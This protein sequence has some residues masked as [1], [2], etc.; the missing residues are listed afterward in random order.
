MT[1]KRFLK[2]LYKMREIY[3]PKGVRFIVPALRFKYD[4]KDE[5]VDNV[6]YKKN[7][8]RHEQKK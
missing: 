1:S 4:E 3:A 8:R 5:K 7:K 2:F 6:R